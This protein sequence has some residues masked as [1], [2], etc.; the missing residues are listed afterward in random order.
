MIIIKRL[1]KR[2]QLTTY[3]LGDINDC[4]IVFI[5]LFTAA[6]GDKAP[7]LV[8]VNGGAMLLIAIQME[9]TLTLLSEVTGMTVQ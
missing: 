3:R 5:G 7:N 4:G 9:V 1:E 2:G 6:V 8:K